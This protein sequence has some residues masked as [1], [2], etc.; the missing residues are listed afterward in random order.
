MGGAQEQEAPG[1]SFT[2]Q[3]GYGCQEGV[4]IAPLEGE[5]INQVLAETLPLGVIGS[6]SL[7][8]LRVQGH[9]GAGIHGGDKI[10]GQPSGHTIAH[11]D[12]D[13]CRKQVR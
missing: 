7:F 3:L 12:H 8:L 10:T 2:D 4:G 13:Q 11:I 6:Q 1:Q 5:K 9:M